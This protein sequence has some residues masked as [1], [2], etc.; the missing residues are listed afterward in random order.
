MKKKCDL[1]NRSHTG[2]VYISEFSNCLGA[3][4]KPTRAAY[5][6]K[7]PANAGFFFACI[8]KTLLYLRW[9]YSMS[10]DNPEPQPEDDSKREILNASLFAEEISFSDTESVLFEED[11]KEPMDPTYDA[12]SEKSM[13]QRY[14]PLKKLNSGGMKTIWEVKDLRTHRTLAMALIEESRIASHED[15]DAFLYEARLTAHLQHPHIVPIYDIAQDHEG[16]PYFTMKALRG[17]TLEHL[18]ARLHAGDKK[19]EQTYTRTRLIEIFL[20][21]CDAV[22][23]AHSKGVLHLDIKPANVMVGEYGDVHLLDWGLATLLTHTEKAQQTPIQWNREQANALHSDE[24]LQAFMERVSQ[25]RQIVG[26][27]PGYMAPEQVQGSPDKLSFQTDIYMLCALLYELL[28]A[29]PPHQGESVQAI[30]QHTLYERVAFPQPVVRGER[31]HPALR[32]ITLKGLCAEPTSR[33]LH[34]STLSDD[35][36]QHMNGYATLAENPTLFTH[37]KLLLSRHRIATF[38]TLLALI[39]IGFI[40]TERFRSIQQRE[41]LTRAALIELQ[42]KK[43]YI[44]ATAVAVAPDYLKL[45]RQYESRYQ[46]AAAEKALNTALTFSPTLEESRY[47]QA[48]ISIAQRAY[49][50]ALRLLEKPENPLSS[51]QPAARLAK[52]YQHIPYSDA[53]LPRM[54]EDFYTYNLESMLPRFFFTLN[55]AP[56]DIDARM[57]GLQEALEV[58]NPSQDSLR[59]SWAESGDQSLLIDAGH[60]PM[61]SN[62]LALSGLNIRLLNL[63]HCARPDLRPLQ[64][65]NL[66]ELRV[67]HTRF[68]KLSEIG[69]LPQLQLLDISHTRIQDISSI[70]QYPNLVSLDISGIE[71]LDISPRLIWAQKLRVLTLSRIHQNHPTIRALAARGVIIQY[72]EDAYE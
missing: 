49:P 35:L 54:V 7:S 31:V 27:T 11:L 26:G 64:L 32:A 41:Q 67:S 38:F 23:Y 68:E 46:Y 66:M 22:E 62:V 4:H 29:H 9:N 5:S 33:Y 24:Q 69:P 55:Q 70:L 14:Q 28:T 21:V 1:S 57:S 40:L 51:T 37:I 50:T 6:K 34:V 52:K 16:N 71:G 45:A 25:Q 8:R 19:T 72:K 61:L 44:A 13:H 10:E 47:L 42:D 39:L 43:D 58:L 59:L 15:I 60:N 36:R 18:L 48:S 53:L 12:L 63:S 30:M 56:F 17:E 20:H 3:T 65:E 2:T